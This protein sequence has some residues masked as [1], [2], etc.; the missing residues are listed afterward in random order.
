MNLIIT[1]VCGILAF[2]LFSGILYVLIVILGIIV[3]LIFKLLE[4]I[5]NLCSKDGQTITSFSYLFQA[6]EL[7][8]SGLTGILLLCMLC[9]IF[10]LGWVFTGSV[11]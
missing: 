2:L 10:G 7:F 4:I 11:K 5:S 8:K 9:A 6:D 1:F 3:S